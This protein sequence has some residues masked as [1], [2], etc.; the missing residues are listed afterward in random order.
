MNFVAHDSCEAFLP[1]FREREAAN[2]IPD[3]I[4]YIDL[5]SQSN[6]ND[7]FTEALNFPKRGEE[8]A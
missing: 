4:E 3:F 6:F 5:S 7:V 2:R 1:V 8:K